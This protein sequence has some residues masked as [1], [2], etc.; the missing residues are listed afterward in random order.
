MMRRH[1]TT[2]I[3][4]VAV[5]VASSLGIAQAEIVPT[6]TSFTATSEFSGAFAVGNLFDATVGDADLG[7][8]LYGNTDGQWAGVGVGPF[9]VFMDFGSTLTEIDGLAYSQRFGANAAADKVGQIEL[10]FSPTDF[11]GTIPGTAPD[12]TVNITTTASAVI[13]PYSLG[14][15]FSGQFVAAQF[16]VASGSFGNIGGS[17][18]RLTRDVAVDALPE[19]TINRDNGNITL[20]NGSASPIN[21]FGYEINSP[22]VGALDASNWTSIAQNY[23]SGNPGPNQ[24]STDAWV[25]FTPAPFIGNLGEGEQPGGGGATVGVGE[26]VDLGNAWIRNPTE[27]LELQLLAD[28]GS[29]INVDIVYT[30]SEIIP[31][32][33]SGNGTVGAEDW[34][35]FRA[36]LG[37]SGS[38]LSVAEAY[39]L[40]D[41]DGDGDTDIRD[42]REFES[43]FNAA[44]GA[45]ALQSLIASQTPE[46]S[47]VVLLTCGGLATLL[48]RRQRPQLRKV[49]TMPRYTPLL[50]AAVVALSF[51]QSSLAQTFT[52]T[53]PATPT[54]S[55]A[56]S[57]FP[58]FEVGM[59]FEDATL[60]GSDLGVKEY[61]AADAQYAGQGV[62]PM[63]LFLDYGGSITA[64]YLAYAQRVGGDPIADKVGQIELWFSDTDFGGV[65]PA[66]A[67]DKTVDINELSGLITPYSLNGEFSGQH[68]AARLTIADISLSQPANN[69][70]GN[71]LRLATGPSDVVLEVDRSTGSMTILNQGNLAQSL[72]ING[73]EIRSANGS[74]L[75]SWDGFEDGTVVGFNPGNG[76]G[77]GWEKGDLSDEEL[78]AEAFLTGSSTVGT[79]AS[80][81]IGVGY[82]TSLDAQDLQFSISITNGSGLL[83]PGTVSYVGG[84]NVLT[85]DYNQNGVV[86]AAD[87]AVWRENLG[88]ASLPNE[89]PAASPGVVDAAD[90][91]VWKTNFGDSG[92]SAQVTAAAPE[93]S[94]L[95]LLIGGIAVF[96]VRRRLAS[97]RIVAA[98]I[99]IAVI[100]LMNSTHAATPDAIYLFG[101]NSPQATE[102]GTGGVEAGQAPGSDLAG[103]TFDHFGEL[104]DG[105]FRDLA[106]LPNL[107]GQRPTYVNTA[108]LSYPG[109]SLGSTTTGIGIRFDGVDD[110]LTGLALGNPANG[111]SGFTGDLQDAYT[112]IFTRMIDGWVRPTSLTGVRQDIVNDSNQFGIHITASNTWGLNFAGV[113]IDSGVDVAGSLDSNGWAHVQHLT[114]GTGVTFLVN[115]EIEF[116]QNSGFYG[117]T[118]A[119]EIVFGANLDK[120]GNFFT[121]DL[122]N[123]RLAVAGDNSGQVTNGANY[124]RITLATDNDYIAANVV[125]GDA[126]GDGQVNG[127]GTGDETVDD[128]SFF[129]NHYLE[130]Q[131]I[132]GVV[133]G[134]ITSVT[135]LADLDGSGRTDILD[136]HILR[137][138]HQ[139]AAVLQGVD[140]G[141]LLAARSAEVPEPTSIVLG[142][143]A[144]LGLASHRGFSR[145]SY[146]RCT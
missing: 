119:Q 99:A 3:R 71:E 104:S 121:G 100:G 91:T 95:C 48:V 103:F 89:D 35:T 24:V 5:L 8:T 23:D 96:S 39:A 139:N 17:E 129:V 4:F 137:T 11:G 80:L 143:L 123:F 113:D 120:D 74:L 102:N 112:G 138:N 32:D 85:G 90:Y 46:P 22:D 115:G 72:D 84:S 76:S 60:T 43:L 66:A 73:Y 92:S 41:L 88:A 140:L 59:L 69:I 7:N 110:H 142:M 19:L 15:E 14:G 145:R 128:I 144:F 65:I 131:V 136:W 29:L 126:N 118:D 68:V 34:P 44:N 31:G 33:Y 105:T 51:N 116:L 21:F 122:D 67:A 107:N 146:F 50:A 25:E 108:A 56:N 77:N 133:R 42:F 93:P 61:G 53:S 127:D 6:P 58:G 12:A 36:G 38:G 1:P 81:P 20:S 62:G 82:N 49:S 64:N 117:A 111:D 37:N 98:G 97:S 75:S 86:D 52:L 124:G 79:S 78:L 109:T 63:E 27:D 87:Y 2:I 10:W 55:T 114:T 9:G 45:G 18:F 94:A 26:S 13:Q 30:G 106:V 70:G 130:T 83:F 16:T 132:N 47:M 135:T 134:D 101:D 125:L 57:E 28:D 54:G 40:G 141:A